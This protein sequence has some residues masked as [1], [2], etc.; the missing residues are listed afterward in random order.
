L[1][2]HEDDSVRFPEL[3]SKAGFETV[4]YFGAYWLGNAYGILRGFAEET[5]VRTKHK[6]TPAAHIAPHV[7]ARLRR[8][9]AAPLFLFVHFLDP[10][11][12]YD[13]AGTHGTPRERYLREVALV[14]REIE[15]IVATIDEEG[16][17]DRT[18]IVLMADHGEAFGEHDTTY[19]ANTLYEELLRVP[20][21]I[22]VPGVAPGRVDHPVSIIDLG[23]TILDL[24]GLPTPGHFMGQ[25]LVPFLRGEQPVLDRPIAA[26]GRLKQALVFPDGTKVIAD[27]RRK[28]LELYDLNRDP[29]ELD[30]RVDEVDVATEPH[31]LAFRAF[32]DA[33][34][35]RRK[36][37]KVPY[38]Y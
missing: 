2:P 33:H 11:E 32:F 5:F 14:D 35:I 30:N 28:T 3:L 21:W 13:L 24:V 27:E 7:L 12:P 9:G 37:Y 1:W 34:R 18:T 38:R 26:E 16:L 4:T 29:L 22:R 17:D 23:P 25:S 20:L 6:F 15:R 31:V 19:H 10:H 8:H 36:G